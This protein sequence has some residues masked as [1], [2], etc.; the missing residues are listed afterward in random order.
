V[1]CSEVKKR[2]SFFHDKQLSKDEAAR[3][4]A[5]SNDCSSCAAELVSFQQLSGLTRRLTDPLVPTRM[6]EELQA[7]LQASGKPSALP[8][9]NSRSCQSTRTVLLQLYQYYTSARPLALAATILVVVGIGAVAYQAWFSAGV[10]HLTVN[11]DQ[12]IK[13]FS[14]RP[15]DAQQIFLAKYD[16]RP[17]TLTEAT[18]I[19]GYEPVAAKGLPPGYSLKEVHL[20]NMPCCTS[21]Q[22]ICTNKAG[23]SIAIFEHAID[24]PV[25]FG[26]RPTVQRLCHNVPTSVIKAG[27]RLAATWRE[28]QRNITIVGATDLEEVNDFIAHFSEASSAEM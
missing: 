1:N 23:K 12:Y 26:D 11:F 9:S 2:L 4:A 19:L 14:E 21:A 15:D 25:R 28:G 27:D 20:L 3:V 7:K 22:V 6:W 8:L 17:T 24:Q 13:E 16:G 10:D 18:N 5:H